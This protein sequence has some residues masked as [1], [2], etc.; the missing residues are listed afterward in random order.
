MPGKRYKPVRSKAQARALMALAA[1]GEIAEEEARGKIR[2]ADWRRLP[3]R[4]GTRRKR[5][6]AR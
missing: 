6:R 4:V 1:R 3:E 2:A 5:G